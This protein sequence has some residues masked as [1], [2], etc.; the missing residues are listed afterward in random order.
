[1]AKEA[2]TV[3]QNPTKKETKT[4]ANLHVLKV[5]GGF[6]LRLGGTKRYFTKT[7]HASNYMQFWT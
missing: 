4:K 6:N 3:T 7:E 5:K 2:K 1:M